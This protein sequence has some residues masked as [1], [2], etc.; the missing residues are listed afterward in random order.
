MY[1]YQDEWQTVLYL[2][3]SVC[4]RC[5]FFLYSVSC[6][7]QRQG[8]PCLYKRPIGWKL[9][10]PFTDSIRCFCFS[11]SSFRFSASSRIPY[12]VFPRDKACL[13]STKDPSVGN[14]YRL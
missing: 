1:S 4:I 14:H 12:P 11:L 13:V 9:L 10:S 8:M 2:Q 7:S 5:F 3:F 6:F